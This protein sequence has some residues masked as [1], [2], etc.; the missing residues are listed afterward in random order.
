MTDPANMAKAIDY[1][2]SPY[3]ILPII[4]TGLGK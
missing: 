4:L 2:S 3:G 1:L